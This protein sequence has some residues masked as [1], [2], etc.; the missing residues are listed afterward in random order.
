[1]P[2]EDHPRYD[3]QKDTTPEHSF[4][5]LAIEL[6][7]DSLTRAR[8]LKFM[9]AALLGSLL[10]GVVLGM[11]EAEARRRRRRRGR[12]RPFLA[13]CSPSNCGGCCTGRICRPGT[14]TFDCGA[15]GSGCVTCGTG[16]ICTAGACVFLPPATCSASNCSG[17]CCAGNS[18]QPGTANTACGIG[19]GACVNCPTGTSCINGSCQCTAG[20]CPGGTTCVNGS[21]QCTAGTCAAG[22][23]QSGTCLPGNSNTACGVGGVACTSCPAGTQCATSGSQAGTCVCSPA[24]CNGCCSN[25]MCLPG[26]L[27]SAC[28][29]TGTACLACPTGATCTNGQCLCGSNLCPPPATCNSTTGVCTPT[30]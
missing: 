4:D 3:D 22:C 19:G 12:P 13:T 23:C 25:G 9:G 15:G 8:A 11:P 7:D 5:E 29:S 27:P 6:A 2:A 16:A 26:N 24:S 30:P 21:C 10:G 20:T 28:G 1:M 17:G 14:T 18:C